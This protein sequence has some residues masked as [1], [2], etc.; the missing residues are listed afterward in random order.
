MRTG[1]STLTSRKGVESR[2]C[3]SS[4]RHRRVAAILKLVRAM[5]VAVSRGAMAGAAAVLALLII[6]PATLVGASYPRF[7]AI[8][9]TFQECAQCHPEQVDWTSAVGND[10]S[11]TQVPG[12][13]AASPLTSPLP[14]LRHHQPAR[15][16]QQ[17]YRY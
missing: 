13:S 14:L 10:R 15:R 4:S 2:V 8:S 11:A 5:A 9:K 7:R 6:M 1:T 16:G 3:M 17:H 12:K